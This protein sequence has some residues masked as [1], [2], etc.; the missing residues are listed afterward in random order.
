MTPAQIDW[1]GLKALSDLRR[2]TIAGKSLP[3]TDIYIKA[4][5]DFQRELDQSF[6]AILA[7]HE[8]DQRVIAAA[9]RLRAA[10]TAVEADQNE[11]TEQEYIDALDEFDKAKQS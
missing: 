11:E 3:E 6:P 10:I 8:R 4:Y 5:F 2:E 7:A 9:D 1:D